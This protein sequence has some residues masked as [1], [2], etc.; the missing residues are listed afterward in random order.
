MIDLSAL[1]GLYPL[2]DEHAQYF[3]RADTDRL[4]PNDRGHERM[5]RTLMYQLMTLPCNF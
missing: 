1:C 5:G 4:H 2:A 3:N